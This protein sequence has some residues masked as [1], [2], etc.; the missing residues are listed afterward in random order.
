MRTHIFFFVF[1]VFFLPPSVSIAQNVDGVLLKNPSEAKIDHIRPHLTSKLISNEGLLL[2]KFKGAWKYQQGD[3]KGWANPD[4]DDAAWHTIAPD[5]LSAKA[6]PDSLWQG[7]GWWRLAFTADSSLYQQ[8]TRLHFRSWGA[9]E[10]YL[11]GNKLNT[12]GNFSSQA[13]DEKNFVP[14]YVVDKKI[15]MSSA[16]FHVLAVRF[17]NH[18][19]KLNQAL[20]KHNAPSLGFNIGFGNEAKGA[21]SERNYAYAIAALSIISA[22]LLLLC[23]LHLLLYFKFPKDNSNLVIALVIASFLISAITN[24][25]HLFIEMTGF[26]HTLTRGFINS[27]FYGLGLVLLPYTI[28]SIFRLNR[29]YWVKHLV[30]LVV[31]RGFLYFVPLFPII[32]SDSIFI[33]LVFLGIGFLMYQAIKNRKPSVHFITVSA[34]LTTVFVLIDRLYATSVI[35]LT[36]EQFYIVLVFLFIS[37]PVGLFVYI[38]RRYGSLFSS[39]EQEVAN[40]TV[41]LNQSLDNLTAAQTTLMAN[42]AKLEQQNQTIEAQTEALRQLDAAKTRFFANVSHELRTPLTLILGPLSTALKSNTLDNKNFTLVSLVKQHAKQLLGLVNEI[43]DLTKLESGKMTL[44]EEPTDAYNFLRR[45]VATFESYA[46]QKNIKLIFDFD[47]DVPRG[48]MLDKSKV[49]RIV[50]N[51]LSNALKFTPKDGIVSVK[52]SHTPSTWQLAVT[53][54]GR[55]IHP[56]DLP[57]VFNRFYQT[58]QTDVP[59][60]GGTGIGLALSKELAEV[61]NG[62][63]TVESTLKNG[64]TF[65]LSLPKRE[66]LGLPQTQLVDNEEKETF[67]V[68]FEMSDI[69]A[70]PKSDTR[71]PTP[72]IR[73]RTPPQLLRILAMTAIKMVK[74]PKKPPF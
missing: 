5:G 4:Y 33:V 25:A 55:G 61:Q 48:L 69:G 72:E 58:N 28:A 50:N 2:L 29:F 68:G 7:Y 51:L 74:K 63:L 16:A 47:P 52:I 22:I 56:D 38:T 14:R 46:T 26:R 70:F 60:E 20:L 67:D 15:E 39:M 27:T 40:R 49:E 11:D 31:L 34:I 6:M 23:G 10:V 66:V 37:F 35:Y 9:A 54:T 59:V 41:E 44:H 73:H 64:A 13:A 30:W 17:S 24:Y 18:Q 57:H 1:F 53:D 45:L 3:D 21:E 65:T 43:L 42:K 71:N 62:T 12:F 36:T 19:A 8:V 32:I